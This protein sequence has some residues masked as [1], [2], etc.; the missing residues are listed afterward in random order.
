M[1]GL[2]MEAPVVFDPLIKQEGAPISG[3][4]PIKEELVPTTWVEVSVPLHLEDEL[5]S[6][7]NSFLK[8]KGYYDSNYS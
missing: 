6:L 8:E 1:S 7:I 2:D 3:L 4:G 5:H